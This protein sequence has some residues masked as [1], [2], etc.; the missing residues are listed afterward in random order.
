MPIGLLDT[1]RCFEPELDKVLTEDGVG[2]ERRGAVVQ[3]AAYERHAA[4]H[5]AFDL[6]NA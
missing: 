5:D 6:E 3:Y 4:K 2:S 1:S